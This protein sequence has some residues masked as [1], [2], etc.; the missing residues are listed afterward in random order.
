MR[1]ARL[2]IRE[3]H[4]IWEAEDLSVTLAR[5]GTIPL[6]MRFLGEELKRLRNERFLSQRDLAQKAGVSPTTIMHLETGESTDPRLS[7]VRKVAEALGVDPNS[8]VDRG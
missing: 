5:L 7:T 6:Q 8:L 1:L 4:S 2:L 3:I